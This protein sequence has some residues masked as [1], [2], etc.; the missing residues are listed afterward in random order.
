MASLCASTRDNITR[1][2]CRS[3]RGKQ[4]GHLIIGETRAE[5]LANHGFRAA[6]FSIRSGVR[7]PEDVIDQ[8]QAVLRELSPEWWPRRGCRLS[9]VF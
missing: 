8:L 1:A 4:E 2:S 6:A 9:E 3:A 7:Q 5:A